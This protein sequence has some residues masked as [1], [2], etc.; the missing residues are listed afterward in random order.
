VRTTRDGF[1]R[2]IRYYLSDAPLVS[3]QLPLVVYVQGSG[4]HSHFVR[5]AGQLQSATGHA[6][7]VDV[8][9]D[10]ARVLLVEKPGVA[11]LDSAPAGVAGASTEFREQHTLERWAEAV[12]AAAADARRQ[13]GIDS[14][15][16]LVLG[17]SEGGLVAATVASRAA[18]V[19]HVGM[20]AGGGPSQ[21]FDL[22]T[23]A[24]RGTFFAHRDST[25][26]GR[27]RYVERAWARILADSTNAD[28]LWF[29]H[30]YR[31]WASFLA[32]SPAEKLRLSRAAV[33]SAQG[34]AD[35]AVTVES[36]DVLCAMLL[37]QGRSRV[38]HRVEGADHNFRAADRA[39]DGWAE[40]LGLVVDWFVTS[41]P[42]P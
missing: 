31:R 6:T 32:T 25:A 10:R 33:F 20:L 39:N 5:R 9:K 24:R 12:R 41:S 16:V 34:T 3:R 14:T 38:C 18:W 8:V 17:H 28:S 29:G 19:T 35:Q 2:T 22:L 13:R 11:F 1:G 37:S 40:V 42:T 21:L 30:P 23:L 26:E 7:L 4:A 15:R 27:A 36:F